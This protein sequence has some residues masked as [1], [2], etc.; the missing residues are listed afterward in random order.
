MRTYRVTGWLAP[1]ALATICSTSALADDPRDKAMTPEAI[2]RDSE[3]IRKMNQDQLD[4]VKRRDAKQAEQWG[5]YK[6]AQR[7]ASQ[8]E[9]DRAAYEAERERYEVRMAR[10]RADVAACRAGDYSRCD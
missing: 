8:Y 4:Y 2:A 10:W 1:I 6:Q 3:T 5:A 7:D 9:R